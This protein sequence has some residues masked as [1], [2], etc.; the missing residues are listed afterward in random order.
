MT[1]RGPLTRDERQVLEAKA[2]AAT[3][4]EWSLAAWGDEPD[5]LDT[6]QSKTPFASEDAR[7]RSV[8]RNDGGVLNKIA[9]LQETEPANREYLV[10]VSPP[11][12]LALLEQVDGM[13]QVQRDPHDVTTLRLATEYRL[14]CE[15]V[16]VA[17]ATLIRGHRSFDDLKRGGAPYRHASEAARAARDRLIAHVS[18]GVLEVGQ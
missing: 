18:C 2:R 7:Q 5:R 15:A 8:W 1:S 4:G 14:A 12:V 13:T 10:A 9:D 17:W 16:Q 3:G 6:L 11:V